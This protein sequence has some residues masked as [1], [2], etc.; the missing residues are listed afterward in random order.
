MFTMEG[1]TVGQTNT[2]IDTNTNTETNR[3]HRHNLMLDAIG[4]VCNVSHQLKRGANRS[5]WSRKVPF[6][7]N[8][9]QQHCHQ[10]SSGKWTLQ[11]C[12]Q[13][14]EERPRQLVVLRT[15]LHNHARLPKIQT[16]NTNTKLKKQ[17]TKYK[18]QNTKYKIQKQNI[19]YEIQSSKQ[20]R[21]QGNGERL[22]GN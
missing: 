10:H 14:N 15:A 3:E 12:Q 16:Q 17:N 6:S 9:Q 13:A 4:W 5:R 11:M 2:N 19:K 7:Q 8:H 21:C 22:K 1:A 20:H 18:I